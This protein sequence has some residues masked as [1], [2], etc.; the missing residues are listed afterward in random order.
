MRKRNGRRASRPRTA[1]FQHCVLIYQKRRVGVKSGRP[2]PPSTIPARLQ[3][4]DVTHLA[5]GKRLGLAVHVKSS[6]RLR[7]NRRPG[8]DLIADEVAHDRIGVA[9]RIAKRPTADRTDMLLELRTEASVRRPVSGIVHA[10][11]YL[12][13]KKSFFCRVDSRGDDKSLYR[14]DSDMI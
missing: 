8:G 13:D 14:Q 6:A 5:A 3:P 2:V 1:P 10:W 4:R 7:G 12:I 9:G 11:R